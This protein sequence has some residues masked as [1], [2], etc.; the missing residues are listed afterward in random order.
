MSMRSTLWRL[1]SRLLATSAL[2]LAVATPAL[3]AGQALVQLITTAAFG[4]GVLMLP[5][6][7]G[8]PTTGPFT[9]YTGVTA[10]ATFA[11][12]VGSATVGTG[13][14]PSVMFAKS[15]LVKSSISNV[16]FQVP[17]YT[18]SG[19]IVFQSK[20]NQ[21]GTLGCQFWWAPGNELPTFRS[22]RW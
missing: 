7:N 15:Q 5:T 8:N 6:A 3:A 21:P 4:P 1:G 19:T 20:Y 2:L 10:F 17:P 22:F 12:G 11:Y 14:T 13:P 9:T 16:T 18:P